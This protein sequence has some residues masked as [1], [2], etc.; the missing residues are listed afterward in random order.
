VDDKKPKEVFVISPIGA[1]ASEAR[2][3]S[4]KVLEFIIR[5]ALPKPE[6]VVRRGDEE[7]SPDKITSLVV[8]RIREADL[9]VADITGHNP[10]VFMS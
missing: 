5:A 1:D 6:F 7:S 9:V 10:N 8:K 3:R 2:V 4:D